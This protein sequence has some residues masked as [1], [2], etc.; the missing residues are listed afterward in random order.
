MNK[1]TERE[2]R[3]YDT[4]ALRKHNRTHVKPVSTLQ[5][6]ENQNTARKHMC[7]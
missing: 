1:E 2:K 6:E 5:Q 4:D 7:I 3:R